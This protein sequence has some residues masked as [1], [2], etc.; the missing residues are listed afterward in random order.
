MA[1]KA[2]VQLRETSKIPVPGTFT[3]RW[4]KVPGESEVSGGGGF[5]GEAPV[6]TF[7][8]HSPVASPL[9]TP[10]NACQGGTSHWMTGG[11]CRRLGEE[12]DT[13]PKVVRFTRAARVQPSPWKLLGDKSSAGVDSCAS[14]RF[15]P[16]RGDTAWGACICILRRSAQQWEETVCTNG[17]LSVAVSWRDSWV[18]K[19]SWCTQGTATEL[20]VK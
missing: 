12:E 8:Q 14:G 1:E 18:S 7:P 4:A 6:L 11:G 3:V 5:S 2:C 15:V 20:R 13:T 9:E 10:E 17:L 16:A 19:S